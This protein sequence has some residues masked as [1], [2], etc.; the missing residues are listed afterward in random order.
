M[1]AEQGGKSCLGFRD[2]DNLENAFNSLKKTGHE[3][4]SA[5]VI[6]QESLKLLKSHTQNLD[7][8]MGWFIL[9]ACTN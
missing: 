8:L 4:Y 1:I 6:N 7:Y 3:Y 9:P 2:E 5:D